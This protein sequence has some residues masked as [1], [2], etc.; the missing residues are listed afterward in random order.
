MRTS[1]RSGFRHCS[2]KWWRNHLEPP[3]TD[4][5]VRWC[6]RGRRVT[7]APMPIKRRYRKLPQTHK[8]ISTRQ[9][10]RSPRH[11]CS[12]Q[13]S[14]ICTRYRHSAALPPLSDTLGSPRIDRGRGLRGNGAGISDSAFSNCRCRSTTSRVFVVTR[15]TYKDDRAGA[16]QA[17]SAPEHRRAPV[18]VVTRATHLKMIAT[19]KTMAATRKQSWSSGCRRCRRSPLPPRKNRHV[20]VTKRSSSRSLLQQRAEDDAFQRVFGERM[21]ERP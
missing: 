15:A 9:C 8:T 11:L 4:P 3:Y 21:A 12:R 20:G 7:A 16:L 17:I 1:N 2:R 19:E 10:F 18:F 5:Y 6:G 13:W 14:A